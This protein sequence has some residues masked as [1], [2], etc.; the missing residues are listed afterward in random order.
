MSVI[1]VAELYEGIY[2]SKD[3][4]KNQRILKTFLKKFP[5]LGI[6]QEI[7]EIF[8]K[9]RGRLRRQ[10]ILNF[11]DGVRKIELAMQNV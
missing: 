4:A 2:Y 10:G 7:C 9:E 6:G 1:S 8:G 11:A 3:P 5:L